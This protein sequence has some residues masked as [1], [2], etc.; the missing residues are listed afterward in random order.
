VASRRFSAWAGGC[1]AQRDFG[2]A[3]GI[4]GDTDS[5]RRR[6]RPATAARS[7]GNSGATGSMGLPAM[8]ISPA[9]I[10][11]LNHHP[12]FRTPPS[13][14]QNKFLGPVNFPVMTSIGGARIEH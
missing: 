8:G 11:P 1:I 12:T 2:G 10:L 4:T 13:H 7:T 14:F 5:A 6:D 3:F 9:V